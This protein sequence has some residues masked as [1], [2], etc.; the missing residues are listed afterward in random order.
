MT[1][2][3]KPWLIGG[4]VEH[5]V[6]VARALAHMATGGASGVGTPRSFKVHATNVPGP[7][8]RIDAGIGAAVS[9]YSAGS[10]LQSYVLFAGSHTDQPITATGAGSGRT[11]LVVARIRD[12]QYEGSWPADPQSGDYAYIDVI[13]GVPANT[14][15]TRGL[16]LS[17]PCIALARIDIPKSTGTITD[18][19][20]TDLRRLANPRSQREIAATI[21]GGT[22]A[23]TSSTK[24]RWTS[25]IPEV[26][27]PA[28]A[29][30]VQVTATL[31][32]VLIT[33]ATSGDIDVRMGGQI[34]SNLAYDFE[35]PSNS[36]TSREAM[37]I[38]GGFVVPDGWKETSQALYLYANR[39]SS[40]TGTIALNRSQVLYDVQFQE[41]VL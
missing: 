17:F 1:L 6:E 41:K 20:I 23:V 30:H 36:V 10:L 31:S 13:E 5:P 32:S 22:S 35:Q 18:A 27:V 3:S 11:D 4:D 29:T 7:T 16:G 26:F 8:V 14:A 39:S 24:A 40:K 15:G 21:P 37:T 19:M 38:T 33:G 25:W 2:D 12:P 34:S 9:A 28:W